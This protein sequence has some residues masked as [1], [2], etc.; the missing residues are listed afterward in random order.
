ANGPCRGVNKQR[1]HFANRV[2]IRRYYIASSKVFIRNLHRKTAFMR[3]QCLYFLRLAHVPSVRRCLL[4]NN[5]SRPYGAANLFRMQKHFGPRFIEHD[6]WIR[7]LPT[8]SS[9][10]EM[11]KVASAA[12]R[13]VRI[14]AILKSYLFWRDQTQ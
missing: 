9:D 8:L 7:D 5:V 2:P 4:Q 1:G 12:Q 3:N 11:P 10:S 13:R 14:V 6:M